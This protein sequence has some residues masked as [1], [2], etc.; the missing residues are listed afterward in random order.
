[1]SIIIIEFFFFNI[2]KKKKPK[3]KV[4]DLYNLAKKNLSDWNRYKS[5]LYPI[6]GYEKWII[7]NKFLY[8]SS[9]VKKCYDISKHF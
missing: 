9:D 6:L 2:Y 1:M 3:T 7:Y 4:E 5:S 8:E